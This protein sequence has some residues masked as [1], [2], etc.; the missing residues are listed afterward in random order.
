MPSATPGRQSRLR[1]R[2]I[3]QATGRPFRAV[4]VET[5]AQH[6]NRV[7]PVAAALNMTEASVRYWLRRY[8]IAWDRYPHQ[9][10]CP[11]CGRPMPKR[12]QPHPNI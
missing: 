5:M 2:A 1:T 3:E 10:R 7:R 9:P 6:A 4:L 11:T 12:A 8:Q